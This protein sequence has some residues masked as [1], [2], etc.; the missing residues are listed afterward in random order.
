[1][2][3]REFLVDCWRRA[4]IGRWG[5]ISIEYRASAICIFIVIRMLTHKMVLVVSRRGRGSNVRASCS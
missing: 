3:W 2:A 4:E 5:C 1:M